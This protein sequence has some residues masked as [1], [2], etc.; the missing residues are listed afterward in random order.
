M[1]PVPGAPV[2]RL[3]PLA[4]CAFFLAALIMVVPIEVDILTP[5]LQRRRFAAVWGG[6]TVSFTVVFVPFL[7]AVLRRRREPSVWSGRGFLIATGSI[8]VLNG[9]WFASVMVYQLFR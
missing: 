3:D 2:Q 6:G 7:L 8:L 1:N 9:L 5:L 4:V